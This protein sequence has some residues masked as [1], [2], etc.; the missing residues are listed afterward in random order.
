VS[1]SRDKY[2]DLFNK[3]LVGD[4]NSIVRRKRR[5]HS[6]GTGGGSELDL[7]NTSTNDAAL[8]GDLVGDFSVSG[9]T[10]V[11]TFSLLGNPGGLFS[12]SGSHLL[13]AAALTAGT[14][15]IIVEADNGAG[16]TIIQL[17]SI[18]VSHVHVG[19]VPTY[20]LLGF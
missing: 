7:S 16:D 13:V 12:I 5:R 20:E 9:G 18:H 11:Y 10:G 1:E 4:F 8:V 2:A 15:P 6:A 14:D 17:F 3:L 19:Y